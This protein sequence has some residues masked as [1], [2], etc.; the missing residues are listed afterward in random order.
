MAKKVMLIPGFQNMKFDGWVK[1]Q[2]LADRLKK[3]GFETSMATYSMGDPMKDSL[4]RYAEELEIEV[5]LI[6]KPDV[7]VAHSMGCLVARFAVEQLS[8]GFPRKMK[9]ILIEGPHQG[10]PNKGISFSR[11]TA[12][13]FELIKSLP[14]RD[15]PNWDSWKDMQQG[16]E[17]LRQLNEEVKMKKGSWLKKDVSYYEIG[18]LFAHLF[19]ETFGLP[20]ETCCAGKMIFSKVTHSWLKSNTKVIDHVVEVIKSD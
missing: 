7:I 20:R 2:K 4:F 16:S 1:W 10:L 5:R 11:I 13:I 8:A 14:D 17:F 19:P 12:K 6:K 9:L 3:E 15:V 18:G